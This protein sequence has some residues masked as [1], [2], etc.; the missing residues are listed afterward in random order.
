MEELL[1]VNYLLSTKDW[2]VIVDNN[3]TEVDFNNKPVFRYLQK[4]YESYKT[5]PDA[6]TFLTSFPDYDIVEV[7]DP[8]E[9]IIDNF[10]F[11]SKL[12]S[13]ISIFNNVKNTV[14]SG[15]ADIDHSIL[16]TL[17]TKSI[18]NLQAALSR[19]QKL[20]YHTGS[21]LR[22]LFEDKVLDI[23]TNKDKNIYPTGF[24]WLDNNKDGRIGWDKEDD[25]VF[26]GGRPG[27]GKSMILCAWAVEQIIRGKN[28][29][30]YEGEMSTYMTL[31]RMLSCFSVKFDNA[32]NGLSVNDF[33]ARNSH[34][35]EILEGFFNT[36][37]YGNL[38]ISTPETFG[39]YPTVNQLETFAKSSNAD[40]LIVDQITLL[41]DIERGKGLWEQETN[42][43]RQL[44]A[45]Q[46]KLQ[47][48]V[49]IAGQ[50]NKSAEEKDTITLGSVYG[51]DGP[52]QFCSKVFFITRKIDATNE[53]TLTLFKNRNGIDRI[54]Q[55]Y[56]VDYSKCSFEEIDA[57]AS[58]NAGLGEDVF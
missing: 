55:L 54:P 12:N 32:H 42:L 15:K 30:F 46:S 13:T 7:N 35:D 1:L 4:Y 37:E 48:P 9:S 44:K 31:S 21:E 49:L 52:A 33:C 47:I 39:S 14:V 26:I 28:V 19:S 56:K 50:L 45:L 41:T 11:K 25:L 18:D 34:L 22:K 2:S 57:D 3:I 40:I 36:P 43:A 20:N 5:I 8:K 58:E 16:D 24:N 17:I 23:Q 29:A 6:A 27:T 53:I 51:S 10:I 38:S